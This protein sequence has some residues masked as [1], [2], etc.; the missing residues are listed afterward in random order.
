M[1]ISFY[2]LIVSDLSAK[3]SGKI[4]RTLTA[5]M[6]IFSTSRETMPS[7]KKSEEL[8]EPLSASVAVFINYWET[9]PSIKKS[10]MKIEYLIASMRISAN[11]EWT[12]SSIKKSEQ[13]CGARASYKWEWDFSNQDLFIGD[14]SKELSFVEEFITSRYDASW[15][16]MRTLHSRLASVTELLDNSFSSSHRR[17]AKWR[18]RRS[19]KMKSI[20]IFSEQVQAHRIDFHELDLAQYDCSLTSRA[21]MRSNAK[22]KMNS[23]TRDWAIKFFALSSS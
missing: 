18:R 11:D 20:I 16:W 3:I 19:K 5:S 4:I 7:I 9:M 17:Y 22:G 6:R 13:M 23:N 10:G 15:Y 14:V 1:H 12:M 21:W 8:I 2:L